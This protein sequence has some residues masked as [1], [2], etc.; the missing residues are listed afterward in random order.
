MELN[1]PIPYKITETITGQ[2]EFQTD[3]GLIYSVYFQSAKEQFYTLPVE[4]TNEAYILVLPYKT[5]KVKT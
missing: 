1:L 3:N 5:M 2:F 4:L